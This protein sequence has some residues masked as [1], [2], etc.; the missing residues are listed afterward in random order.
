MDSVKQD[1]LE[2]DVVLMSLHDTR[3]FGEEVQYYGDNQTSCARVVTGREDKLD[4]IDLGELC[5]RE[6]GQKK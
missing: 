6:N 5:A 1:V 4:S 3:E 2:S